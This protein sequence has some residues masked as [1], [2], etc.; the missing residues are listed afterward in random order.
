MPTD[1][2]AT[3]RHR[4][5]VLLFAATIFSSAFLLFQVQPLISRFILPWFGGSPAVWSTCMLFFQVVLFAG[6]LYAHLLSTRLSPRWQASL[7]AALLAGAV[8]SLPITPDAS[9]KPAPG[10]NPTLRIILLLGACVGLPYLLLSSTGPLLQRWFSQQAPGTSPYRLY[11]LSNV[12]S[13]LALV[14]F[15]FVV[16][17]VFSS[18]VQAE[19]WSWGFRAFAILCIACAARQ[20]TISPTRCAQVATRAHDRESAPTWG[21]R[22]MWF[23]LAAVASVMLLATTNQVCLDVATVPF[24]W[25]LPLTI[26]LLSFILCFDGNRWYSRK[27]CVALLF[28]SLIAVINT[29]MGGVNVSIILQVLVYLT[30]LFFC[31]MVCHGELA[32][33]KPGVRHLTSFY[34]LISAGGAVGGVFVGLIAPYIFSGYWELHIGL[35]ACLLV[36]PLIYYRDKA[37]LLYR[38]GSRPLWTTIVVTIGLLS[39]GLARHAWGM[40]GDSIAVSRNFYGV[41]R[42]SDN[43]DQTRRALFHGTILHG[44]QFL[45]EERRT[46]PTTYYGVRSGAGAVLQHHRVGEPRRIGIVGLG[47]GTLA[48]YGQPGDLFRCYEINPEVVRLADE[49]FTFLSDTKAATEVILGDA[50]LSLE[51]EPDQQYDVLVLDAFSGDAIPTHLLTR[52]AA[53]L[54]VR[55]L[56]DD[57]ILCVHISNIHF[58][59]RPVVHGVAEHLGMHVASVEGAGDKEQGTQR[60]YWMLLSR[61]PI[62]SSLIAATDGQHALDERPVLWTDYWSNLLSALR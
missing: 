20:W 44:M 16:E 24:L 52:E 21:D 61:R 3:T 50:R 2:P 19:T 33:Q 14:T 31:C 17:P 11:A 59:L 27:T 57:G 32:S 39:V 48:T 25:I 60:C 22:L 43:A 4:G 10:E 53:D 7:H 36:M 49:Y 58:D 51:H 37:S 28:V 62:D 47:V 41:L 56:R 12:G 15:P 55:H 13:L 8:M 6:Y 30:G 18:P 35:L 38:G 5:V 54:Y 42:V 9:W 29:L 26:Y 34:L 45:D 40:L 1:P 23:T 46:V